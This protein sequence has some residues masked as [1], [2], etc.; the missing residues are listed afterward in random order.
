MIAKLIIVTSGIC[1]SP[2]TLASMSRMSFTLTLL[3]RARVYE[4]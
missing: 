3:A 2:D 4:A 1:T